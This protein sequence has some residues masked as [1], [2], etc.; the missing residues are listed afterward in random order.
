VII[1]TV[2][3]QVSALPVHVG[4]VAQAGSVVAMLT[5]ANSPLEAELAV[6]T[7]AAGFIEPGQ[8]VRLMYDAFP[9]QKFGAAEGMIRSVSQAAMTPE[10]IR[11]PGV[12][13]GEPMFIVRVKLKTDKMTGYG[14]DFQLRPGLMLAADVVLDR[15]SLLEWLLDPLF[16]IGRRA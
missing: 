5:P 11:I 6:P 1:A 9:H 10:D 8:N 16:A 14:R 7:R 2:D 3:G 15:R 4:D 12:Q 13:V